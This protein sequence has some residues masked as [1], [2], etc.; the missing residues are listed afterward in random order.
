ME[1]LKVGQKLILY[2]MTSKINEAIL[3]GFQKGELIKS[4][5]TLYSHCDRIIFFQ[6]NLVN[7]LKVEIALELV[8]H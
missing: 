8:W 2:E 3:Y 5:Q 1:S 4:N 6:K 7:Y